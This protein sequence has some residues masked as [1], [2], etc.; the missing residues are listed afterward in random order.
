MHGV[1]VRDCHV[2]G[3]LNGIRVTRAGFRSLAAGEEYVHELSDVVI[4]DSSISGTR[5]VGLYV[6][7]YVSEV[8]IRRNT[9]TGA[10]STGIY[11]EAGSRR[12]VVED[13]V[14]HDN[15][16]R[17]NSRGTDFVV[18][19]QTFHFWG[20]GRE[21]LAIDGSYENRVTGNSFEGNSAGGI[22]LYTNCGEYV[23]SRPE[24]W[25]E[26]RFGADRNLI[27][28]NT[29][30]GGH[31]GIW[32]GSR[33]GENTWP[34]ECSD[35]P[36]RTGPLVSIALD[37]AADNVLRANTFSDVI[38]G[39]RVEDDGTVVEHNSFTGP[40]PTHHAV[41]VGTPHR[42]AVL[43]RPVERL[44]LVG[45]R[46]AITGN[47]FPYRWV[48]GVRDID[49]H[50]NTANGLP[51]DLCQG[52]TLPRSLFVFV[53]AVV[54]RDPTQPPPP[55]PPLVWPEVGAL[56]DCVAADPLPQVV[57]RSAPD[58][59]GF[60]YEEQAGSARPAQRAVDH[61][62][63]GPL[64]HRLRSGGFGNQAKPGADYKAA[65]GVVTFAP[66]ETRRTVE[67]TVIGDG[68]AEPVE[69]VVVWFHDPTSARI[70]G[71]Y[72]LGFAFIQNDD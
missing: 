42:T 18:G 36:Y 53:L 46:A 34:M 40:D 3:F 51:V 9:I 69:H 10:G 2:D 70:G 32:V 15:G 43:G 54:L 48:E 26:R 59:R 61:Q 16:F 67:L 66:G 50:D 19:S 68:E 24:R 58:P 17:E 11:L 65:S 64:G 7:G 41:V 31:N 62:R 57:P 52:R 28:G 30:T 22:F 63:V 12:N 56:P 20:I 45:N 5:G 14:L 29:F 6:D 37:R 60:G 55:P 72:G 49:V 21:G 38:Y 4:E 39:V 44:R 33:M 1:T 8:T 23:N 25:F 27:Q 47:N 13:N 71:L 35:E